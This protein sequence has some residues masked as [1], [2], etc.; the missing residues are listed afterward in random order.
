M[1]VEFLARDFSQPFGLPRYNNSLQEC[2]TAAGV[3]FRA[4]A[5]VVPIWAQATGRISARF[6]LDVE[7]FLGT[8]P[9]STGFSQKSVKH[10]PDY[11]MA[12]AL[13]FERLQ[14]AVVT[15][16]D[17]TP[18]WSSSGVTSSVLRY[19][20]YRAFHSMALAGLRRAGAIITDTQHVADSLADVVGC[21]R[22]RITVIPLGVAHD[23][24]RPVEVGSD[25]LSRYGLDRDHRYI[26]SVGTDA[27]RKNLGNLVKAFAL[28]R[29]D[30][31]DV[32]LLKVGASGWESSSRMV[33]DLIQQL[34]LSQHVRFLGIV[35]DSDLAGLYCVADVMAYPS[36]YEG[37]GLPVL[38]A[39][40]CGTP[41][42][43]SNVSCLPEVAGD[44]A[45]L[46]DPYDVH[47]IADAIR[48]I[49]T[50]AGLRE[51][52]RRKGIM[53]ALEFTWERTAQ[54]T[55]AVY[56]RVALTG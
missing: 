27:P 39:M 11:T 44:A 1:L 47:S 6:G 48:Q 56:H 42:V 13:V 21:S 38:E 35:P 50:N 53:H 49:L 51:T 52:Q 40:A 14:S 37:F 19:A 2:L 20:V 7:T 25:F 17:F 33:Q 15:V 24:F 16:H 32:Q 29:R 3:D 10:L 26:V 18:D 5:P 36:L 31:P 46:A 28:V 54:E 55:L 12:T 34:G 23:V 22:D 43:T 41:V 8:Y 45:L 30:F 4:V 9:V